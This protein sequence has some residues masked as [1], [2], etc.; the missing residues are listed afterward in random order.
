[1]VDFLVRHLFVVV[2]LR[3]Q[4]FCFLSPATDSASKSF[5]FSSTGKENPRGAKIRHRQET[6]VVAKFAGIIN[7]LCGAKLAPAWHQGM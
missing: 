6:A 5:S 3:S 1:V 7:R 2:A 4:P